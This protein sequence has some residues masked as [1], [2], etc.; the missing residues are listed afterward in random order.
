MNIISPSDT[1]TRA[2]KSLRALCA[3]ALMAG[4][5]LIACVS[6][7]AADAMLDLSFGKQTQHLSRTELLAHPA[8]R[9]VDIPADIAY[10]K[11]MRFRALPLSALSDKLAQ[12]DSV[13]FVATDGFVANIPGSLL[14]GPSQ[15][16]LAI[17]PADAPWPALK[18]GGPSAGTFYLVW[19]APEKSGIT[20][21]QWPYQI[22]KIAESLPLTARFPQLMPKG[23][24]ADSAAIRGLGVYTENCAVCHQINGGGD[25]KLGPDL[26]TPFSPTEYF[27]E[28]YLRKLIRDP[29]SVR[30]WGQRIMPGFAPDALSDA[31]LDD[32]LAY[33]RQM[34]KQRQ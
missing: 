32:L 15:A 11:P 29:A 25:A 9:T 31:K 28:A 13:Q 2:R 1:T 24:S 7:Q 3:R 27:H 30:N 34:A 22:G 26:N 16:W 5:T 23:V 20:P 12:M 17:E 21:E 4:A 19:L 8:V 18:P 14:A 10:K 6:A 33:L